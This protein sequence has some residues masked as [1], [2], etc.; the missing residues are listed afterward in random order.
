MT[1]PLEFSVAASNVTC[2]PKIIPDIDADSGEDLPNKILG[3]DVVLP[4]LAFGDVG[5][6]GR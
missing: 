4:G 5:I 3:P 6:E 1:N 2:W